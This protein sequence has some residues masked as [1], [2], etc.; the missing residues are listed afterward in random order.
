MPDDVPE[1]DEY[2]NV[3]LVRILPT[4]RF[5]EFFL[6]QAYKNYVFQTAILSIIPVYI[7]NVTLRQRDFFRHYLFPLSSEAECILQIAYR[8][9]LR[10]TFFS[11]LCMAQSKL[12]HTDGRDLNPVSLCMILETIVIYSRVYHVSCTLYM[13]PNSFPSPEVAFYQE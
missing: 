3:K 8:L 2:V 5:V 9:F 11:L 1:D 6:T 4:Y 12:W 10:L 7:L 13:S